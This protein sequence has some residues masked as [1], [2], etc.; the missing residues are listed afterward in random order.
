M[1]A[2]SIRYY[3]EPPIFVGVG[4]E[5]ILVPTPHSSGIGSRGDSKVH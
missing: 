2:H 1:A 4:V 3:E 5:I